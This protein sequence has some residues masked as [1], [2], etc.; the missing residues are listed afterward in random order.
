MASEYQ[1]SKQIRPSHFYNASEID[2]AHLMFSNAGLKALLIPVILEQLLN[3][4]MGMMDTMMVSRVGSAA[5][6][7]VSLV[8]SINILFIQV[9]AALATG[10]TIVCSQYIGHGNRKFSQDAAEQVTLTSFVISIAI[11]VAGLIWCKP[12]LSLVFGEIEPDVMSYSVTYF[13]VTIISYPFMAMFQSGSAFYR[14]G[15]NSKFPMTVSLISNVMNIIGN[16]I[17]IFGFGWGVFGAALSTLISRIFCAVVIFVYLRKPDQPIVISH[18]LKIRPHWSMIAKVLGIGIPSGIE[19]GM[20]QFGKLAI[21]SS[22]SILGT[23]AIA[24]QAMTAILESLNGIGGIGIGI[25]LMT[26]VGQCIG[27]G[28]KEE[29]KY[30]IV[31]LTK[32]AYLVVFLSCLIVYGLT[33]PVIYIAGMEHEAG[34]LCLN[35]VGWITVVKPVFWVLA[36]VPGYGMRAAGDVKFSMILSSCTMWFCR[37]ALATVLIRVFGFGPIAV[38]IGMFADWTLRGI[39][40]TW[41]FVSGKWLEHGLVGG[42]KESQQ[43]SVSD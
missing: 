24:A 31:K 43:E 23:T 37:V 30:Y 42:S 21:Q 5:I 40:Y 22:V 12:I 1:K 17:L 3:S 28:K 26:V 19:N 14:A 10:G 34:L 7:A 11:M 27:A 18:Y 35:M 36:F 25:G 29:A 8:D 33:Y 6:S 41:R 32:L 15:G 38:W 4:F 2:G 39:S 13:I 20:F 16:A 9:F